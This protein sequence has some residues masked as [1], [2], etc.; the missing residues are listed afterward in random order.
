MTMEKKIFQCKIAIENTTTKN[1]ANIAASLQSSF[2]SLF[3]VTCIIS[4]NLLIHL[5]HLINSKVK[6]RKSVSNR[7]T[8][9]LMTSKSIQL[10]HNNNKLT[11][12]NKNNQLFQDHQLHMPSNKLFNSHKFP[13]MPSMNLIR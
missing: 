2:C 13:L 9:T 3:W 7:S 1:I 5:T 12:L 8:L 10:F 4:E 11:L 6:K